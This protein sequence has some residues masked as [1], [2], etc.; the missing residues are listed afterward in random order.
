[1][2]SLTSEPVLPFQF[3]QRMV[4][5]SLKEIRVFLTIE[6]RDLQFVF[7]QESLMAKYDVL[8]AVY[9]RKKRQVGGD[10]WRLEK[11][12]G[13]NK[14]PLIFNDTLQLLVPVSAAKMQ[15]GIKDAFGEGVMQNSVV[16]DS[17]RFVNSFLI[18][19]SRVVEEDYVRMKFEL[20]NLE[21]LDSLRIGV[22]G[23][24]EK[25]MSRKI[26]RGERVYVDTLSYW[27]GNTASGNYLFQM[28][29]FSGGKVMES[30]TMAFV[31]KRSFFLEDHLYL[32]KVRQLRYIATEGEMKKLRKLP[33]NDR[34]K[35]WNEFWKTKDEN[36]NTEVNETMEN[37]FS[38]IEYAEEHFSQGD[39]GWQSD[40]GMIYVKLGPPDEIDYH[41]FDLDSED[42]EIWYYYRTN[43]KFKFVDIFGYGEFRLVEKEGTGI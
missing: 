4:G 21:G 15:V 17:I 25:V 36:P 6:S 5:D 20:I 14:A 32:E 26:P 2:C 1:M 22:P 27:L 10:F 9:D 34:E 37:Y 40:R 12:L 39:K 33:F 28:D 19:P 23:E 31:L 29:I 16:L 18:Y 24:K 38:R 3:E 42:Y 8:V 11:R 30:K 41:H 13:S 35:G 7:N 43:R